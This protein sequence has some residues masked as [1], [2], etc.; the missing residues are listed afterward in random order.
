MSHVHTPQHALASIQWA[1]TTPPYHKMYQPLRENQ[2]CS[3]PQI[4]SAVPDTGPT[5]DGQPWTSS[6]SCLSWSRDLSGSASLQA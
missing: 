2:P 5:R 1:H 4:C 3:I 6:S